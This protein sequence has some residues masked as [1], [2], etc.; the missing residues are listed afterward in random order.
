MTNRNSIV[1]AAVGDI[2]S[3]K[4]LKIFK[5]SLH[6][7]PLNYIDLFLLAGDNVH[8]NAVDQMENVVNAI[9]DI[10]NIPIVSCFGNE[11]Y[12]PQKYKDE[13]SSVT[14]LD[15]ESIILNIK[16]WNIKIIGTKGVLDKPTAWQSKNIKDI[17]KI[18]TERLRKIECLISE[19]KADFTVLL[20][21]YSVTYKTMI[22]EPESLWP[23][24]GSKAVEDIILRTNLTLCIHAHV[25]RSRRKIIEVNSTT[26]INVSLPSTNNISI[27][28]LPISQTL[29]KTLT[30]FL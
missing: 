26:I 4:F 21:H 28:T 11:E 23:L 1:I 19:G 13:Y 9:R 6:S 18:Y 3:P 8:R 20:S 2:H 25:H 15:D 10:G 14:W 27:I 17:D 29:Q 24:L 30:N 12:T 16:G 5:N 22:G 7:I